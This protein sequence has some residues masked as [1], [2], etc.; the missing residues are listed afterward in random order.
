MFSFGQPD[1]PQFGGV[2]LMIE[3]PAVDVTITPASAFAATGSL[4]GRVVKT[5]G[6]LT[7]LWNMSAAPACNFHVEAPREH[8]GLGVGTQLALSVAVGIRHFL[9]GGP[10]P[11]PILSNRLGRGARSSIGTIGFEHGGLIVDF[12][13]YPGEW[14][15]S[16]RREAV[17]SDWR[18]VLLCRREAQGLTGE[19]EA[20]A[21]KRLPPVPETVTAELQRITNEELTAAVAQKDCAAFGDAV[22]RF[23]RL[24]G[25]CF[26]PMQGGPF[27][28]SETAQLVEAVRDYGIPG[29]GQSS[30]GP[31][32]FAVTAD[33]KEAQSLVQWF[34]ERFTID[35]YDIVIARPNNTGAQ[36][37][38][39]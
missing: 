11:V 3:Q 34:K 18:F 22:Y 29:V 17:P 33:E 30:W 2:G 15:S 25:E 1:R 35:Q 9:G 16:F 21:F 14:C 7:E 24:A 4:T 32:I 36:V 39:L 13:K 8:S 12:G 28:S 10:I 19:A 27:A 38:T 37:K 23:G 6:K 5:V 20:A 31:T 26:A